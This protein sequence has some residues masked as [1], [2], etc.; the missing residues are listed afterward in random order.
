MQTPA[1]IA[2]DRGESDQGAELVACG[3]A[4]VV[5]GS[6]QLDLVLLTLLLARE[7]R[8]HGRVDFRDRGA[9]E[10][11]VKGGRRSV[12][13]FHSVRPSKRCHP[14]AAMEA[15]NARCVEGV[16]TDTSTRLPADASRSWPCLLEDARAAAVLRLP[17]P[18][19][20]QAKAAVGQNLD[21]VDRASAI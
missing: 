1:G 13:V 7:R 10:R 15:C 20:M 6:N 3:L 8:G 14:G 4:H 2:L 21:R 19:L 18:T 11:G 17:L 5:L 16:T 9:E 12:S